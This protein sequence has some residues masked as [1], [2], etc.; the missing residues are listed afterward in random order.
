MIGK[1]YFYKG[2]FVR[3]E[4]KFRE[5]IT[6]IPG[7]DYI[8]VAS[9]WLGRSLFESNRL[10]DAR[11]EITALIPRAYENGENTVGGEAGLLLGQTCLKIAD[12][13]GAITAFR[14]VIEQSNDPSRSADAQLWI[15]E[16]LS[17]NGN[18][19][20]VLKAFAKVREY[21]PEF[22]T[23]YKSHLR[24][25]Q[26]LTKIGRY[27]D[28]INELQYL[29]DR[30]E[31]NEYVAPIKYSLAYTH[32][33]KGDI[34][35]AV[36]RYME[37]DSLY[38][39][40][41]AAA[42]SY[43]QRGMIQQ[44]D[45]GNYKE[46]SVMFEKARTENV[47]SSIAQ[48]AGDY[49]DNAKQY[50]L[51]RGK[52]YRCDSL[53][54]RI[55]PSHDT[56]SN[57]T[58]AQDSLK[59][60]IVAKDSSAI[61]ETVKDSVAAPVINIM[62]LDS[63]RIDG[64]AETK[65]GHSIPKDTLIVKKDTTVKPKAAA[66]D[67]TKILRERVEVLYDLGSLLYL[68]MGEPDSA[69]GVF[70]EVLHSSPTDDIAAGTL[71]T[72]GQIYR[73]MFKDRTALADSLADSILVKYSKTKYAQE[74][75]RQ[76]GMQL[77]EF[78]EEANANMLFLD[79]EKSISDSNSE[80]A[81]RKFGMVIEKYPKSDQAIKAHYAIGWHY[82]NTYKNLDSAAAW[83]DTLMKKFPSS[84]YAEKV[85]GKLDEVAGVKRVKDSIATAAAKRIAK[86]SSS[87]SV[88][89]SAQGD[90]TRK[91]GIDTL[92]RKSP[93]AGPVDSIK[94]VVNDTLQKRQRRLRPVDDD[95]ELPN[96]RGMKRGQ[97]D[98]LLVPDGKGVQRDTSTTVGP[99]AP[100]S[101][102][103]LSRHSTA[104]GPIDSVK[105]TTSDTLPKH[106]GRLRPADDEEELSGHRREKKSPTDTVAV[107]K[108]IDE[109]MKIQNLERHPALPDTTEE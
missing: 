34:A 73:T 53:L 83:Y 63:I 24:Y 80:T 78:T 54:G 41:D 12:T 26:Y 72:L 97:I 89:K 52:I 14:S 20:D 91:A 6:T 70:Q 66:L 86:D 17:V 4:R 10:E 19:D 44:K 5:L 74:I 102:D 69:L 39:G 23:E 13:S 1:A 101:V 68:R 25:A 60:T 31:Y 59:N 105:T 51:L 43:F 79:A 77:I 75:R 45:S 48:K 3:A 37:I 8:H 85:K 106:P 55:Q 93:A 46:A 33:Q 103:T 47:Q 67:T 49:A 76:R 94:T 99:K 40:S 28:A 15:A 18:P 7:S 62:E 22:I 100:Q 36:S 88:Q 64:S 65:P 108:G 98:T 58:E 107:P 95:E 84:I 21:E 32:H 9:L 29:L 56:V 2:D 11:K 35:E 61:S 81:L 57:V 42:Q 104:P 50:L 16:I 87:A 71:F 82:E 27:D 109:E 30:P 38:R 92:S 96:R 90:S